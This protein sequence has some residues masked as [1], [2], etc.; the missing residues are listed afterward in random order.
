M[1]LVLKPRIR[2]RV[3]TVI[4]TKVAVFFVAA[5]VFLL[6]FTGNLALA[7]RLGPKSAIPSI[8]AA[9]QQG[10]RRLTIAGIIIGSII[11]SLIFASAAQGQWETV[12]KFQNGQPF[13]VA[14]PIFGKDVSFYM[15]SLPFQRL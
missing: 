8:P 1:A 12:L 4:T 10:L 11:L 9:T 14:D 15:F 6:L 5:V 13:G 3:G 7:H 2:Q